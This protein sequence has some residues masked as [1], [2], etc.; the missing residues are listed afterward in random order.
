MT[1]SN[2]ALCTL[3]DTKPED[4]QPEDIEQVGIFCA[5]TRVDDLF[6]LC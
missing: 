2:S 5:E 3:R 1:L 4:R 6:S